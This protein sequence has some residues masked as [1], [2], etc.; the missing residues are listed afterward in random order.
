MAR[1]TTLKPLIAKLSPRIG[2]AQGE[3]ARDRYRAETQEH[4]AW[5]GLARWK[6][7]PTRPGDP[8]GLRWH[9]LTRDLFTCQMCGAASREGDGRDM[10]ADHKTPHRG[11]EALFWDARNIQCLCKGCHDS[12]KQREERGHGRW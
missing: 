6:R 9:V 5:Y 2:P 7:K 10:V 4:R 3:Q 8:G 12:T 1:L 11:D